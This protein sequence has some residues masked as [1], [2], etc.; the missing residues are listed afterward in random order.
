MGETTLKPCP[1]PECRRSVVRFVGRAETC[2]V[3]CW[4]CATR[5]PS[6]RPTPRGKDEVRRLWNLLPREEKR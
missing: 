3:E 4:T 1:N 6:E 2:Y 5:G